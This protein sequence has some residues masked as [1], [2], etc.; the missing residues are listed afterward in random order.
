MTLHFGGSQGDG[1]GGV[2]S[3]Y[4][5]VQ[6]FRSRMDNCLNLFDSRALDRVLLPFIHYRVGRTNGAL[7]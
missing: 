3:L 6:R 2:G 4:T 7:S 5:T 1:P